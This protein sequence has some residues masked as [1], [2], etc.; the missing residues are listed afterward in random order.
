M[1]ISA[2]QK[3]PSGGYRVRWQF[4][5]DFEGANPTG[6]T[7]HQNFQPGWNTVENYINPISAVAL[8]RQTAVEALREHDEDVAKAEAEEAAAASSDDNVPDEL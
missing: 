5:V 7:I 1:P 3:I 2:H 4:I 8:T 6:I